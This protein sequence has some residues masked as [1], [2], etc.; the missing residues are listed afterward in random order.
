MIT[1]QELSSYLD[2]LLKPADFI[3]SCPNGVQVEGK[4]EIHK[5]ACA[6]SANITIIDAAI[7]ARADALLVHHGLFWQNDPFPIIGTKKEKI[8]K[9][10]KAG[11]TLF[12][13]HLPLDAHCRLGNNWKAAADMGWGSLEPFGV[14][15]NMSIGVKGR[16]QTR[17]VQDFQNQLEKYYGHLAHVALGGKR[18][19]S[20]GGIISGG[21][22]RNIE[23]AAEEKLDCYVTGSFDEPIWDIAHERKINFFA[24]GHHATERIGIQALGKEVSHHFDIPCEFIDH[25]NPF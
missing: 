12:A 13:F 20:T 10:L 17:S 25:K 14:F 9:L 18:E 22:H 7:K 15:R 8:E 24:L 23:Q 5:M 6:V 21:A 2:A 4:Q 11:I 19:V 16:F 1:L 3:D